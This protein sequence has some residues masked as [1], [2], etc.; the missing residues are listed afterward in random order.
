M[1]PKENSKAK[2][3]IADLTEFRRR[4][5]AQMKLA[6]EAFTRPSVE[7]KSVTPK[8][9]LERASS[10]PEVEKNEENFEGNSPRTPPGPGLL[11]RLQHNTPWNRFSKWLYQLV[12]PDHLIAAGNAPALVDEAGEEDFISDPDE[13]ESVID[14]REAVPATSLA[15]KVRFL[16]HSYYLWWVLAWLCG[17]S[18]AVR[19]GWG[20]VFFCLSV[21]VVIS[22]SLNDTRKRKRGTPSAY[23]VF[24]ANCERI[25]GTLDAEQLQRQMFLGF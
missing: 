2:G 15:G 3:T 10:G 21:L 12:M 19:F 18:L 5:A 14:D 13:V 6:E 8:K 9:I 17:F 24:N 25:E 4:K 7:L 16:M 22:K 23:S 20:A 11:P 1:E